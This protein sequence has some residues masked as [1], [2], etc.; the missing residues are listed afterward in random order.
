VI[1]PDASHF[2]FLQD[3]SGFNAARS[4]IFWANNALQAVAGFPVGA[5]RR[6][7][8]HPETGEQMRFPHVAARQKTAHRFHARYQGI[9]P[10]RY[11]PGRYLGPVCKRCFLVQL[12]A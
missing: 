12:A 8:L 10:R 9:V 4:S 6:D 7:R 1:L 2:A 5:S 3:P 11:S